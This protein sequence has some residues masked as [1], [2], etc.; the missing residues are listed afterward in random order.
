M[1]FSFLNCQS[2]HYFDGAV[3]STFRDLKPQNVFMTKTGKTCK[4]GK[5]KHAN[6]VTE[7]YGFLP[8]EE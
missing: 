2:I 7:K 8:A 5:L 4:L 6:W 1:L 3:F